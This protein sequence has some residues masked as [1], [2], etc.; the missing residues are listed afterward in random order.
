MAT[1]RKQTTRKSAARQTGSKKRPTRRKAARKSATRRGAKK[2]AR[3]K[4]L[5]KKPARKKALRK[6]PARRKA[7]RKKPARRRA[8]SGRASRAS[9]VELLARK[10]VRATHNPSHFKA[11]DFYAENCVSREAAGDPASGIAGIEA[12]MQEWNKFQESSTWKARNVFVKG[13]TICIEWE[14]EVKLRGGPVVHFEEIA[15]HEVKNGKIAAERYYYDPATLAPQ[16]A[17]GA[18]AP[19]AEQRELELEAPEVLG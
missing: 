14:A 7:V 15:V 2:S 5:R 13:N 11:S 16:P 1:R 19:V 8:G 4:A 9:A 18:S 3:K 12:K 17:A 10:I 6:K